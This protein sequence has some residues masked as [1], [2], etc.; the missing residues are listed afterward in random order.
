MRHFTRHSR[1]QRAF[2]A[3][4][5]PYL[6][7]A[8][9]VDFFHGHRPEE[10]VASPPGIVHLTQPP[11]NPDATPE[12]SCPVCAWLRLGPNLE[13]PFS[14]GTCSDIVRMM[15][16]LPVP[17]EP[18]SPVPLPSHLRAPPSPAIA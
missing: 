2:V 1:W 16:V 14:L 15:V 8:M 5:L 17:G 4:C 11:D 9:F 7:L 6:L 12:Y 18:E 10:T 13:T 3:A